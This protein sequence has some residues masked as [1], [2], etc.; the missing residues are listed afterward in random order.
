[1]HERHGRPGG[2]QGHRAWT[3]RS[4]TSRRWAS[5]GSPTPSSMPCKRP[6]GATKSTVVDPNPDNKVVH[7]RIVTPGGDLTYKTGANRT[8]TWITEYLIK[9]HEDVELIEKY[10]PIA[11]LDHA[12]DPAGVR[13]HRRG[14][15]PARFRLGRPG[16]LLAARLLPDGGPGPDPRDVREPRLGAPAARRPC[17]KRSSASSTS[18]CVGR[19]SI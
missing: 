6:S 18:R 16:R 9:R 8:T 2:V 7:H 12:G 1:M 13:P 5:S 11:R 4:S 19:S 10:M 14:R 3:P 17:W 15:H